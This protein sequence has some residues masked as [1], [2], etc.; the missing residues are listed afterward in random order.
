MIMLTCE[1]VQGQIT[2]Q[3]IYGGNGS[4][5][6][7]DIH[8]TVDGG[9][10][11][12]GYTS[13]FGAGGYD[14]Y[15]I[16][17]DSIGDTLWTKTFG[18]LGDDVGNAVQQTIDGGF[19]IEGST[20]S[21]G[22]GEVD[23]YLIKTDSNGDTLWTKT[24]GGPVAE[25][26][27]SA[28]QTIDGGYIIAGETN[29]NNGNNRDVYLVKT[30]SFGNAIWAKTYDIA[31]DDWGYSV[32]QTAD[33]G[34]I[35]TG[36]TSL[37]GNDVLLIKTDSLGE[38]LWSKTYGGS[39]D[40]QGCSVKQTTD[41]GYIVVGY[42]SSFGVGLYNV[43]LIK[44]T[45]N[46]DTLWTKTYGGNSVDFGL[47]VQ[48]TID[49]GYI[50]GGSSQSFTTGSI[51]GAYLIKTNSLGNMQWTKVYG[52]TV[53][54]VAE[55]VEQ[56]SDGGYIF[57]GHGALGPFNQNWYIVKTDL[58]GNSG[59][60]E[61]NVATI[62]GSPATQVTIVAPIINSDNF[63]HNTQTILGSG[64]IVTTLCDNVGINEITVKANNFIFPNPN[65]GSFTISYHLSTLK[66]ELLIKDIFSRTVYSFD[67]RSAEGKHNINI[68]F[69]SR[70][71]Y[72]WQLISDN[73]ISSTGKLAIIK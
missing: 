47:S 22:G 59:C 24:Y 26:G 30:D 18:G 67:I 73:N 2:F 42:T 66:N 40:D 11:I 41:G 27:Y 4:N 23:V 21:F 32:Q 6:C 50:I 48:Q 14:V 25:T 51:E 71:I 19:I 36:Y 20:S 9:Y 58:H 44:T 33:R 49:G 17:I 69:L 28:Q 60:N 55:C 12:A 29:S 46:G 61:K 8:Q 10:I 37:N 63:T 70:G 64:C 15:L 72:Y 53:Q 31:S 13:S 34:Y 3:K 1:L 16:K 35:I 56:T 45:S 68:S 5:H 7:Q 52:D 43:Y 39:N 62:Q 65:D 57:G 54:E 38:I